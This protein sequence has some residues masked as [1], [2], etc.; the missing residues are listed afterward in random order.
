MSWR[1][2]GPRYYFV[3][4]GGTCQN[5]LCKRYLRERY[6]IA[7]ARMV[8]NP[9]WAPW[10]HSYSINWLNP[11][12]HTI[13]RWGCMESPLL[14]GFPIEFGQLGGPLWTF[15]DFALWDWWFTPFMKN[16]KFNHEPGEDPV[17]FPT[18]SGEAFVFTG[19]RQFMTDLEQR[20]PLAHTRT[21]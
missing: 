17:F 20:D 19:C 3:A 6:R 14:E 21:N 11:L 10:S 8:R 16:S 15:F 9:F 13:S 1:D 18:F 7:E 5:D 2:H 12:M 4:S